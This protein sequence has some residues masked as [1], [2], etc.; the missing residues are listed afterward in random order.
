MRGEPGVGEGV[1]R[2]TGGLPVCGEVGHAAQVVV[3]HPGRM[4][5]VDVEVDADLRRLLGGLVSHRASPWSLSVLRLLR[6][7]G[8]CRGTP[9]Q[10][11]VIRSFP[12][13]HAREPA[14]ATDLVAPCGLHAHA[15]PDQPPRDSPTGFGC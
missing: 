15:R 12:Y 4:G 14:R 9:P 13:D 2:A 3:V 5:L 10:A 1:E 11:E 8:V 6:P 7:E